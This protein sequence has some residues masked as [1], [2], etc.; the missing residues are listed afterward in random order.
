MPTFTLTNEQVVEL[1]KQ[2]PGEQQ[3]EVFRL[4]LLQQWGQWESLSRY[5]A[6]RARLVAQERGQNWDTMTDDER[7]A[8]VNEVVHED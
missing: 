8:F 4:L 3:I 1:V 7:E 6:G 2:L 5:G